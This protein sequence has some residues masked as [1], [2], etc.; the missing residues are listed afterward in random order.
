MVNKKRPLNSNVVIKKL[1]SL[2]SFD[3]F[4]SNQ[5]Y[6][7]KKNFTAQTEKKHTHILIIC[8]SMKSKNPSLLRGHHHRLSAAL[9][10]DLLV[11]V[12][13]I[14]FAPQKQLQMR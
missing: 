5:C 14:S 11:S 3:S 1:D 7:H 4:D 9:H 13:A 6:N 2:D 8:K 12:F 10:S